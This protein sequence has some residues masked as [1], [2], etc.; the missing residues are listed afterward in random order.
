M[1]T[2]GFFVNLIFIALMYRTV[3]EINMLNKKNQKKGAFEKYNKYLHDYDMEKK[4]YESICGNENDY[5]I[6]SEIDKILHD[7]K[8]G[9][10][11][12][13]YNNEYSYKGLWENNTQNGFGIYMQNEQALISGNR[14]QNKYHGLMKVHIE[15]VPGGLVANYY[16]TYNEG[17][18]EECYIKYK[19][20]RLYEITDAKLNKLQLF[21]FIQ[22]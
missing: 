15:D 2:L 10:R 20:S 3:V 1:F 5:N 22:I 8:H 16:C 18:R 12:I 11:K 7:Y 4:K 6:S 13:Y 9:C 14:K 19:D 21:D 17:K